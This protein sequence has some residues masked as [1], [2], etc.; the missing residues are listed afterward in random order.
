MSESALQRNLT[1]L[2]NKTIFSISQISTS[3]SLAGI[4]YLQ[5]NIIFLKKIK[6]IFYLFIYLFIFLLMHSITA[7]LSNKYFQV[8]NINTFQS[9]VFTL[10]EMIVFPKIFA[11]AEY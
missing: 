5:S 9:N 11:H 8:V 7:Y 10:K 1:T 3:Q 4:N 2:K 6:H